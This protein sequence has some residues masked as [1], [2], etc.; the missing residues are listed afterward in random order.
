VERGE[1]APHRVLDDLVATVTVPRPER[2]R[3]ADQPRDLPPD[4]RPA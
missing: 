4:L 1:R 2:L 3:D